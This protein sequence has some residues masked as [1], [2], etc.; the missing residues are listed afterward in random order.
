VPLAPAQVHPL[1]H[2]GPVGRLGAAGPRADR[3]HRVLRVVLAGEQEERPLA[4]EVPGE[5]VR[6]RVDLGLGLG[7]GGIREQL[8][9]LLDVGEALLDDPPGLDLLAQALG[10]ADDLLRRA[11]VVPEPGLDGAGV[12]L[13]DARLLG[14]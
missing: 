4:L 10:L 5:G 3:D 12:E 1:E 8:E 6:L 2:L 14:G 7:V 13:R 11:L 9:E